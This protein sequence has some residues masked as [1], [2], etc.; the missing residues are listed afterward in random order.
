M[1][2]FMSTEGKMFALAL[3]KE[4]DFFGGMLGGCPIL[5][6]WKEEAYVFDNFDGVIAVTEYLNDY[7]YYHIFEVLE[8]GATILFQTRINLPFPGEE[9]ERKGTAEEME[10]YEIEVLD[11]DDEEPMYGYG[12]DDAIRRMMD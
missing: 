1:K 6:T 5:T 4:T 11:F 12:E 8:N 10:K 7:K 2:S 9:T 3:E